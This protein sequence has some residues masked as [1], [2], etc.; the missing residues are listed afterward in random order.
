VHHLNAKIPFYRLPEAMQHFPE[1]Q[2]CKVTTL[3][4][5][6]VRKCL[7]LKVWDPEQNRMIGLKEIRKETA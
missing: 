5:K 4:L 2:N 1:L 7:S 6:D 3:R